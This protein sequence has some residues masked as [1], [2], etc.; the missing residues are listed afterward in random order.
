MPYDPKKVEE[1]WRKRWA[2]AKA[3]EPEPDGRE[4]FY[5]TVAYPY[6]S[7]AMHVGHAR[8][9]TVPDIIARFKRMQGFNVLFPMAWHVTGTPII[10]ALNR[11]KSGEEKQLHVLRDIYHLSDAD[12]KKMQVPMDYA[13]YFIKNH[14]QKG[15]NRMGY[16]I[17]WR[18]QFTTN[19]PHYNQ[20]VTWQY[21]SLYKNGLVKEGK[22]PV[23]WCTK[24]KNPVTAHDLLEGEEAEIQEWVLLKFKF[25]DC[26]IIAATLRPETIFGQTNM[27]VNPDVEYVKAKV[28]GECWIIS[29]ECADKLGYQERRIDVIGKVKGR[30][31]I[32]EYITAPGIDR[33][34]IVLPSKFCDPNVG[35]GFVTSVPSDAPFDWIGLRDLQGSKKECEKYGLDWGEIKA[36]QVIPIIRTKEFGDNAALV[37]SER[38]G[39]KSQ[40]DF[41]KLEEATK[42][43]YKAGF[44]T[45]VMIENC[46]DYN[47]MPVE[48]AK[49]MVKQDLIDRGLADLMYEFSEP[50]RC[51]CGARVVVAKA[52]SWFLRYSDEEWKAKARGAVQNMNA[53]PETTRGEYSHTIDWLNDWPCVRNFGL[54]TRLPFDDRFMIEPLSDSTIYMAYYTISHL[55]KDLKPEQLTHEFFD[56][57][58]KNEGTLDGIVKK[59]KIDKKRLDGIKKSFDYWYP[60]NWRCS[61][62][63]LIGNHLTFMLF[64]H[65]ALFQIDKWPEGIVCFGVGLLEGAKM[66]SSKGNVILLSDALD[67]YGADVVR[68][69]LMSN[70]EPWQDF[71]WRD[72]EVIGAQKSLRKFYEWSETVVKMKGGSARAIDRWLVSK[73]QGIKKVMNDSMEGFQTRKACQ[74]GFFEVFSILRW[75]EKRGGD[76]SAVL[77]QFLSEWVRM[78]TPVVPHIC[79]EVWAM[80]GGKG[81]VLDAEYPRLDGSKIDEKAEL[82]ENALA[83]LVDDINNILSVTGK[84]PKKLYLYVAPE[85]KFELFGKIAGGAQIGDVMK[86][87][88]FKEHGNEVV[89]IFKKAKEIE[90]KKGW[91]KKDEDSLLTDARAFLEK[92]IGC[93]VEIN[94]SNDPQNKARFAL[95]MKPAIYIE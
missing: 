80:M 55:I 41:K 94:P 91:M 19:D 73:L 10:G 29:S 86:D 28:D 83:N 74:A 5:I 53:I 54:G 4:R 37:V 8:T 77:K 87:G 30:E 62:S 14:Y 2:D 67:K 12:L 75:Y 68:L 11:L 93:N 34:I 59:T 60:Q 15:M 49:G 13:Q 1:K 21:N 40:T 56:F 45:G 70:A 22:H 69:F 17:D 6:P 35:T 72:K 82:G 52:D 48:R 79:E 7:G 66:S 90:F 50:V 88:K 25:G 85:W 58:F 36:I 27:W 3:F 78:M 26:F 43:V 76:N 32:G 81:F 51:R 64:H 9:Y 18:R 63:E 47:G 23:K 46:G 24:E 84:E 33:D 38:T 44:H 65:T 71:D 42:E 57:V 92:E 61:A 20:F 31:L 39:I 16:T 89:N 95:P